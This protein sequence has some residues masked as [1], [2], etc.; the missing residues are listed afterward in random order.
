MSAG[1]AVAHS[2]AGNTGESAGSWVGAAGGAALLSAPPPHAD[3]ASHP[4]RTKVRVRSALFINWKKR[5]EK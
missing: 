1:V 5:A 3:S 2:L 4:A